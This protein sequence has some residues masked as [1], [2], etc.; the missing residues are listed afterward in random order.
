VTGAELPREIANELRSLSRLTSQLVARRLVMATRLLEDDPEAAYQHAMA[1]QHSAG[2]IGAVREA[3]GLAAYAAGHYAEALAELRTARRIT[4]SQDYLPVMADCERGLGRPERAL[5]LASSREVQQLD[6]AGQVEMRIV[7]A[8]A[9]RDMGQLDAAVV[10]LQGPD[11]VSRVEAPWSARLRY[12]Y[13]DALLAAGRSAEAMDWFR[14]AADIDTH[15]ET[16]AEDRVAEL[17][18]VSFIDLEEDDLPDAASDTIENVPAPSAIAMTEAGAE[19]KAGEAGA[20][21]EADSVLRAEPESGPDSESESESETESEPEPESETESEPEP[22]TDP[23]ET[24]A[25]G[26][27]V[28]DVDPVLFSDAASQAPIDTTR[29]DE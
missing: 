25:S 16:D 20:E 23:A 3:A 6:R 8:G 28:P 24:S 18:G 11:L 27:V 14:R 26:P 17:E 9:R 4:G 29:D 7:A 21:G 13:A 2:R 12:A 10:T 19:G 5:E 15:G 22:E 1:A